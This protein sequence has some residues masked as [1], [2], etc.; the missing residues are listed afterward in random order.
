M[1][2]TS[3]SVDGARTAVNRIVLS[4]PGTA[5]GRARLRAA[6]GFVV[7]IAAFTAGTLGRV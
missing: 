6:P 5:R 3:L 1:I 4:D 2:L 7:R